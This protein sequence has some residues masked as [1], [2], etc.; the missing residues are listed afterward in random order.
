M[1]ES[2]LGAII[3]NLTRHHRLPLSGEDLSAIRYVYTTFFQ[4]G[5]EL[6]YSVGSEPSFNMP[7]Y[8]DLMTEK[9]TNGQ[10]QSYLA[11]EQNFQVVKQLEANNLLIPVVG[12]FSGRTAVRDVGRYLASRGVPVTAFYVS[13]VERYLFGRSDAWRR[14]YVN[15]AILPYD[16]KSVF[17]RSVLNP[18]GFGSQNLLCPIADLMSAFGSGIAGYE[19]VIAMSNHL[20]TSH[21]RSD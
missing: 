13:N 14:F 8:V 1:F 4:A 9:D 17:I 12:D 15:V 16:D 20:A 19:D 5:P 3:D 6:D 2:N 7:T 10:Y 21:G 11:S 18:P